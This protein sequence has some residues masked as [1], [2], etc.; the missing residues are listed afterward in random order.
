MSNLTGGEACDAAAKAIIGAIVGTVTAW[1]VGKALQDVDR[2]L[3]ERSRARVA[4]LHRD[5]EEE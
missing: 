5:A 3:E 1:L 4:G 2:R